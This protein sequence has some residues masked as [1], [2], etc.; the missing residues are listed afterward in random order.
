[1]GD[2][3]L[4]AAP[5]YKVVTLRGRDVHIDAFATA[6][7]ALCLALLALDDPRVDAMLEA[8]GVRLTDMK[9]R[10]VVFPFQKSP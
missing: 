4:F 7:Y 1:M 9:T 10:E 2:R 5:Q 8:S 6:E 3:H